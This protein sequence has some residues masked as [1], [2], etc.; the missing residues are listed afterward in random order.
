MSYPL[1]QTSN[2]YTAFLFAQPDSF[3]PPANITQSGFS[4]QTFQ[5]AM[6]LGDP[7]AGTFFRARND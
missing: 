2:S 6:G 5:G 7:I 4:L 3:D 1:I